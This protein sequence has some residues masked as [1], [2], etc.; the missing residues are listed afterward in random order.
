MTQPLGEHQVL[1]RLMV[2][3][4]RTRPPLLAWWYDR[5]SVNIRK[6]FFR[7]FL[8]ADAARLAGGR[9]HPGRLIAAFKHLK[10][11]FQWLVTASQG[12]QPHNP[13]ATQF[14]NS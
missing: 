10:E 4:R 3:K 14:P 7:N 6:I 5:L 12:A 8:L 1:V 13:P 11:Y 9:Y 2:M